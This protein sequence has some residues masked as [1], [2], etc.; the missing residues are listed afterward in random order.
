MNV[1][2]NR[3]NLTEKMTYCYAPLFGLLH[4]R[5]G[6]GQRVDVVGALT[7][8]MSGTDEVTQRLEDKIDKQ[9]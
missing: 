3:E 6:L 5:V 8:Q 9:I 2:L 1:L 7:S 4:T